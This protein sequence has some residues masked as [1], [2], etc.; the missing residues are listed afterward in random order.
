M[1]ARLSRAG[2]AGESAGRGA[3]C[4][5]EGDHTRSGPRPPHASEGGR[6]S[7]LGVRDR[8]GRSRDLAPTRKPPRHPIQTDHPDRGGCHALDQG[9]EGASRSPLLRMPGGG[10][11]GNSALPRMDMGSQGLGVETEGQGARWKPATASHWVLRRGDDLTRKEGTLAWESLI[12]GTDS[13]RFRRVELEPTNG[14]RQ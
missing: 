4:Q 12:P 8:E 11:G 2:I 10:T 13:S 14:G 6:D 9:F 3:R 7:S 1:T 5:V